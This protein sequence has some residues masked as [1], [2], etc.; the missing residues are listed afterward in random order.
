MNDSSRQPRFAIRLQPDEYAG[1][2]KVRRALGERSVSAAVRQVMAKKL[3]EL[4][5]DEPPKTKK[6]KQR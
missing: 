4:G 2:E 3:T 1:W 6:A 5:L